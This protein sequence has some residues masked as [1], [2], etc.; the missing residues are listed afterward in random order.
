MAHTQEDQ[1]KS[2]FNI[3]L[4][5]ANVRLK[6]L[7][8][9]KT[10]KLRVDIELHTC[11]RISLHLIFVRSRTKSLAL[12]HRLVLGERVEKECR[13]RSALKCTAEVLGEQEHRSC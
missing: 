11:N 13:S 5:T 1:F 10:L 4:K 3:E 2:L 9:V 7:G 12:G 8:N 6:R